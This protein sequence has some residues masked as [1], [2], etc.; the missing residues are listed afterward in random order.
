MTESFLFVYNPKAGRK[1]DKK[2]IEQIQ[3]LLSENTHSKFIRIDDLAKEDTSPFNKII[4]IG[5]DGTVNTVAKLCF[6]NNKILGII[7]K[8]SGDGLA[9]HLNL[10]R[11]VAQNIA[12]IERNKTILADTAS[13]SG[14]FFINVAGT[15]F[16]A[17]VAHLFGK[18][19][20]RGILGYIKTII[21]VFNKYQERSVEIINGS[22]TQKINYFSLSIANGSQWGNDFVIANEAKL[23][24]GLLNIVALKKPKLWQIPSLL[25]YL[26]GKNI[27]VNKLCKNYSAEKIR[28]VGSSKKWHIDGEPIRLKR[29]NTIEIIPQSLKILIN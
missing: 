16:E 13:L 15:G 6:E 29:K 25:L 22:E 17:E 10:E 5:G 27:K 11:D 1:F 28:I 9:R 18:G 24:D 12:T 4:A 26:K 8:G 19:T 2:I 21:M 20:V 7:P 3:K 14:H 23:N